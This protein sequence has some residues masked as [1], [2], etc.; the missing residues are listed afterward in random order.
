L[1]HELNNIIA[2]LASQAIEKN[3]GFNLTITSDRDRFVIGDPTRL[4]QVF[5]NLLSNAIKFTPKGAI[6]VNSHLITLDTDTLKFTST[7][8]DSGIGMIDTQIEKLFTTFS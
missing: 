4:R 3:L 8:Q 1:K 2:L 6:K 7:I 5:T